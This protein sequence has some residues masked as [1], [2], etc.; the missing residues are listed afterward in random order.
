MERTD[1]LNYDCIPPLIEFRD[2]LLSEF[3]RLLEPSMIRHEEEFALLEKQVMDYVLA[4][5][6]KL[7]WEF[8]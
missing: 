6:N 2:R 3:A 5:L 7:G 8:T 1:G 4:A